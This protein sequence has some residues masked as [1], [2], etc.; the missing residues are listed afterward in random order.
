MRRAAA[1][2]APGGK[3]WGRVLGIPGV[4]R[5][6]ALLVEWAKEVWWAM[7]CALPSSHLCHFHRALLSSV[8]F[9]WYLYPGYVIGTSW[10]SLTQQLLLPVSLKS[11]VQAL[12]IHWLMGPPLGF[13]NHILLL[14]CSR[15][16]I[17]QVIL[18]SLSRARPCFH[19]K[20]PKELN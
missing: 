8:S 11:F 2:G 10:I 16:Q 14:C 3:A 18:G 15:N 6:P 1:A 9:H 7:R 12:L 5:Q 17:A 13:K 4:E 19:I 20:D